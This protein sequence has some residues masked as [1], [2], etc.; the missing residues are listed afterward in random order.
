[1]EL[2]TLSNGWLAVIATFSLF[3]AS[4][5]LFI[6]RLIG[7]TMAALLLFFALSVGIA[8]ANHDIIRDYLTHAIPEPQ[9]DMERK[10]ALFQEKILQ[11]Y[12][13]LKTENEIQHYKLQA[14]AEELQR[15]K[16]EHPDH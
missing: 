15:L 4:I 1:M 14:L 8:V 11:G 3:S 5:T 2:V 13:S 7:F 16:Q 12:E 9:R 10:M 6:K